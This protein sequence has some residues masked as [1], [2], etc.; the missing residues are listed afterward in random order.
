MSYE[1]INAI[2]E[3]FDYS[4]SYEDEPVQDGYGI[5]EVREIAVHFGIEDIN[6]IKPGIGETT[7]VLLRRVPWKV[8]LDERYRDKGELE[9]I[10]R[11]AAEKKVDI[12]Y[13]P[14]RHYKCCGLIKKMADT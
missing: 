2:E 9:H 7:R 10:V 6:L 12:E 13:Y 8:L 1:F 3:K 14:L 11:L 5:D 4:K